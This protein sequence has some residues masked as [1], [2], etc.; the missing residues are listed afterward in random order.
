MET[1][2]AQLIEKLEAFR[3]SYF[4]LSN[5]W[6]DSSEEDNQKLNN[7]LY[8][9]PFS[10]DDHSQGVR[11]WVEKSIK[12]LS[13][14][15]KRYKT[16]FGYHTPE[17]SKVY[18]DRITKEVPALKLTDSSWHN[19]TCDSV[20]SDTIKVFFPNI[21][22]EPQAENDEKLFHVYDLQN[23]ETMG[24]PQVCRKRTHGK[25]TNT[26]IETST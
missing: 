15:N 5:A 13:I 14:N 11:E 17:Q 12:D 8:P 24:R 16:V 18:F 1:T 10:F 25:R 3:K 20:S 19:D 26:T 6:T 23:D 21:G 2:T 4:D 22:E 7:G 9:F